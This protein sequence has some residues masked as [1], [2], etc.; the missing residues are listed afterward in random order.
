MESAYLFIGISLILIFVLV[1]LKFYASNDEGFRNIP[2]EEAKKGQ[3]N[4]NRGEGNGKKGKKGNTKSVGGAPEDGQGDVPSSEG[5][6]AVPNTMPGAVVA[7]SKNAPA[8]FKD[9]SSLLDLMKT[10]NILYE[11]NITNLSKKDRFKFLHANSIAYQVKIQAQVDTGTVVDTLDFI[12]RQRNKYQKAINEI[13]GTQDNM[14]AENEK[15]AE[16]R[17]KKT[18]ALDSGITMADL[19]FVIKRAKEE[20][21]RIDDLRSESSD[22]KRRSQLL[23]RIRLDLMGFVDRIKRGDITLNDLPFSKLELRRFLIEIENP[24]A[25][26]NALPA[27]GRAQGPAGSIQPQRPAAAQQ[28]GPGGIAM[29]PAAI[30]QQLRSA[31]RDLSWE[32]YIGYDP[33]T[34]LQR[35]MMERLNSLT[36]QI[37]SGKLRGDDKKAKMLELEILQQQL[38]A[39]TRRRVAESSDPLSPYESFKSSPASAGKEEP[40]ITEAYAP[41]PIEP[42]GP[43]L[44]PERSIISTIEPPIPSNDWRTRPGYQMSNDEIAKRGTNASFQDT[45]SGPDYKKRVQFLCQQIKG[46]DLG[47][48]AEFGCIK[49][50]DN[51]VGPTY[52]WKGNYKMVCSRLGRTWGA[53]YPEMFGCPPDQQSTTQV[54]KFKINP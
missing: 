6:S 31:T 24:S 33:Q 1:G 10:Y 21:K 49:D 54:P 35:R 43:Q 48:P 39:S 14:R 12:T 46:A 37:Q 42:V 27:L 36:N 47:D 30:A 34:T 45:V 32:V 23:E 51:D 4:S 18:F 50:M 13:R 53:W 17:V 44:S 11:N 8:S 41:T 3:R 5:T 15:K 20:Q 22:L 28:T 40:L 2:G 19:D 25:L 29:N 38:D 26:I 52:S 16:A 9:L 7:N